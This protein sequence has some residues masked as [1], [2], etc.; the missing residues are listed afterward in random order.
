[1]NRDLEQKGTKSRISAQGSDEPRVDSALKPGVGPRRR[2]Y[3]GSTL[4]PS[5]NPNRVASRLRKCRN[6]LGL[7]GVGGTITQ[8]SSSLKILGWRTRSRWDWRSACG[9]STLSFASAILL[10]LVWFATDSLHAA[11]SHKRG[12]TLRL[13]RVNDPTTLDPALVSSMVDV[14]LLPLLYQPLIDFRGGANLASGLASNW[15]VST[16][17]RT[18]TFQLLPGVRFSNGRETT[19]EDYLFTLERSVLEPSF[20]QQYAM[21]IRGAPA[22][23]AARTNEAWQL[24]INA[25]KGKGRWIE[26][27]HLA[28][29]STPSRHTLIVELE[30]PDI[31]FIY[32]MANSFGMAIAKETLPEPL[33]DVGKH[34]VGTGPY[35]IKDW[36]RGVRIRY[37]RNPY[38][39]R[40]E[41]QYFDAIEI[42]IGGDESTHLM[43]FERGEL[44]L[45]SLLAAGAPEADFLRLHNDSRWKPGWT[46]A[47]MFHSIMVN[48]NTEMPPL[49]DI[50]VRL[51]IAHA[52]D[53][54]KFQRMNGER[55]APGHGGITPLMPGFDPNLNYPAY[56]PERSCIL[57]REAGYPKDQPKPLKFWHT[58]LQLYRRWA[59]AIQD[60]LA[61][62]GFA[63]ELHEVSGAVFDNMTGRRNGAEMSLYAWTAGTPDASYFLLPFHSRF[64]SEESSLNSAFYH[65][66]VVD[67]LLDEAASSVDEPRRLAIYQ[68]VEQKLVSEGSLI[69]LGHQNLFALRQPWL[70]GPLLEPMWWFRLDRVWFEK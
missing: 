29:V 61:K 49:N 22:F 65:N 25:A 64:I 18:F 2:D 8:G 51:A 60:D 38:Y 52:I 66:A 43:M 69:V 32:W 56:D 58:N 26:P 24:K 44:D 55:V 4:P 28:G 19:A 40:P 62:V 48:L 35:V 7:D 21:Q 33:K 17:K 42:M 68:Q 41:Q 30:K 54:K 20:L 59:A 11:E 50:R 16:D 53:R 13:A 31:T 46:N 70:K 5:I 23:L 63:I 15:S 57:L 34:P 14:L 10:A 39:I 9:T 6:P 3:A 36:V 47:P 45:A 1:M 27:T 67:H 12:G 37:E